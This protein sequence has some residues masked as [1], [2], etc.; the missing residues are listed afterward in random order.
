MQTAPNLPARA[1]A[2]AVRLGLQL[3]AYERLGEALVHS[4][5]LNEDSRYRGQSNERL[6]FLGDAVIGLVIGDW[7][8]VRFPNIPEGQLTT[9]R[10]ALVRRETLC[11]AAAR[12]DLG[13]ALLMGRGEAAAGSRSRPAVLAAAFEAVVGAV[14]LECGYDVSRE[15]VLRWLE[16]ELEAVG[17]SGVIEAD[18]KTRLQ[19]E[20][21]SR[22]LGAPVYQVT[23]SSGPDHA[24]EFTIQVLV[25]GEVRGEGQGASKRAAEM[26]A[27][28]QALVG[29]VRGGDGVP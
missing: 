21:Q 11:D 14:W 10:A 12:L 3:P 24:R 8:F 17:A 29:F 7:L 1:E 27:A 6:E 13:D 25:A 26:E 16:P 5:Y 22:Q 15:W 4:S 20:T 23:A 19:Q 28:R 18:P 2:L 9:L